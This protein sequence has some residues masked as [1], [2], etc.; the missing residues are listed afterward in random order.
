MKKHEDLAGNP[1]KVGDYVAYAALW[2]RS[3]TLKYGR[4]LALTETKVP[5]Y[6]SEKAPKVQVVTVD[7]SWDD[8]WEIQGGGWENKDP[9]KAKLVT[10]GFVDRM[11]VVTKAQIPDDARKL[12]DA[13]YKAKTV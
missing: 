6:G 2:S 8:S 10:L 4:V 3:A 1:I 9:A 7:R 12:L 5:S 11:L 13:A